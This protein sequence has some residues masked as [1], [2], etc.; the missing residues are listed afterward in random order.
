MH[1]QWQGVKDY[2]L[3]IFLIYFVIAIIAF[4]ITA[5]ISK[6]PS[7]VDAH[8]TAFDISLICLISPLAIGAISWI[9][10]LLIVYRPKRVLIPINEDLRKAQ[11][12]QKRKL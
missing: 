10:Y 8:G 1:K 12:N 5:G 7:H 3:G 6:T 2:I 9:I 4:F 11:N